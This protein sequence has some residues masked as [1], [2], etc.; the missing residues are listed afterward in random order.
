MRC[1]RLA[2]QISKEAADLLAAAEEALQA[3]ISA[4]SPGASLS[5]VGNA[6]AAV[7]KRHG[8]GVVTRFVGHGIGSDFHSPPLV[9]HHQQSWLER[10]ACCSRAASR[11]AKRVLCYA[12]S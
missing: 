2:G 4:V 10:G 6:V 7:V 5:D 3:G 9:Y 1:G 11:P 8:M 12:V